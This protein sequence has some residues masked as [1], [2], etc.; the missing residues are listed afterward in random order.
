MKRREFVFGSTAIVGAASVGLPSWR[1]TTYRTARITKKRRSG[2]DKAYSHKRVKD[3]TG[4]IGGRVERFELRGGD[5]SRNSDCTARLLNGRMVTRA[6]TEEVWDTNLRKGDSGAFRYPLYLPYNVVPSVGTT[7]G[8]VLSAYQRG[9]DYDSFPLFSVDTERDRNRVYAALSQVRTNES[10]RVRTSD[11]T[12][13]DKRR[14]ML[15]RWIDVTVYFGLSTGSD[16]FI[17]PVIDGK[18]ITTFTGP[19]ILDDGYLEIRYGIYQTGTNQFSGGATAVST[20]VAY[21]ANLQ[22]LRAS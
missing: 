7:L 15:D 17:T 19:N 13:G 16:G 2:T 3:P 12:I 22:V 14:N 21:Y 10:Q 1:Q 18:Q 11:H 20:Q 9:N 8:Q 6:R 4:A 5:C